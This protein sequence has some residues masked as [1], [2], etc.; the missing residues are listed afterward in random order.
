MSLNLDGAK[1]SIFTGT[2]AALPTIIYTGNK[3]AGSTRP[4]R[5]LRKT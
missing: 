2:V 4:R 5:L 1:R 3:L